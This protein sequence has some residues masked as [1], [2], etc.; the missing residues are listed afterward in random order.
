M[1]LDAAEIRVL[2]CL[3]EKQRTTP[4]AYPLSLNG[5][6]LACNQT[7]NRDPVVSYD[8]TTI[9]QAVTRLS[10]RGWIRLASGRGSRAVKYRHLLDSALALSPAEL[11]LLAVLM[12]RGPQTPGELKQR[13][14][15]LQPFE[16]LAEI[17]E[18]L[19]ALAARDLAERIPR[20]PGQKEDRYRQ[21]LGDEAAGSEPEP[22]RGS[23]QRIAPY[24]LYGDA[25][26]AVAWLGGAF[27]FREVD[28]SIG[29][30][31]GLHVELAVDER[32]TFVYLGQ[33]P[34][35]FR[36]PA[37]VGS[38]SLVWVLV[39]DVDA[40]AERAR[41]AGAEILEELHDAPTGHR[42]YR[43][44]DPQGHQW[45]FARPLER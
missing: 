37:E 32:G 34:G 36:G 5:L 11:A 40:H 8:E 6:R 26:A 35:D 44:A 33:P 23:E 25:E 42:R 15:R 10:Q 18:T 31:G 43:C 13:S 12:L 17:E 24:L 20:R 39:D 1:D 28:R 7:T 22:A 29:A 9:R 45:W 16:G 19:A 4:D 14:E 2:G 41:A 3:V 21:L 38:T 27:G 30:A